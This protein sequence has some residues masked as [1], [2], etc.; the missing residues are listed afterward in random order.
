MFIIVN[1]TDT[2][3]NPQEITDMLKISFMTVYRWIRADKLTTM[4]AGEQY[5]FKQTVLSNFIINN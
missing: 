2:H 1:M 5:Y 4:E 3:L